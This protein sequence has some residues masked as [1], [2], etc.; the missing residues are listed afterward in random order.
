MDVDTRHL[1]ALVAVVEEGTFTDAA[2][3]LRTSQAS[4][5]RSVQRL[6]AVVGLR[7]LSRS[8]RHVET[9]PAGERVLVHA[10]RILA[11]VAQLETAVAAGP[12]MLTLGYA[13][14]AFGEHTVAVQRAWDDRQSGDLVLVQHNTPTAG[15]LEGRCDVSLVRLPVTDPRLDRAQVGTERRYA[16]LA[17]DHPRAG[18]ATMRLADLAGE[19][20]AVDVDSGTTTE[21]LWGPEARPAGFRMTHGVDEWLNLIASG[22]VVGVSSEATAALHPRHG[23]AFRPLEDTP[24]IEV[25]L[26][27]WKD[28]VPPLLD[29]L[30]EISRAAY[31]RAAAPPQSL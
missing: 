21:G 23:V 6:E 22:R 3:A 20:V 9:T 10:R 25:W 1:R 24:L 30:V 7:L 8:T 31:A 17:A 18:Q 26:V 14:A 12:A 2:I 5:T 28:D 13:W 29:E 19:S 4:I 16:V 15:L 27:W 11:G